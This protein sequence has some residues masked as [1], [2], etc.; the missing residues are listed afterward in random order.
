MLAGVNGAL[1][2][3]VMASRVAYGLA[4]KGQAFAVWSRVHP[5]TRTPLQATLAATACVLV[6]AVWFPLVGLAKATSTILLVV[7]AMV[8]LSLWTIKRAEPHKL[9]D[10]PCYPRWLPLLGFSV[11]VAF[12]VFHAVSMLA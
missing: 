11:S 5:V 3:I 10:G 7:Y 9:Y 2:Q 12:L 4:K 8:N 6:L 1:V